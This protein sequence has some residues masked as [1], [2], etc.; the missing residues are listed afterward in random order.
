MTT[1]RLAICALLV[2]TCFS[3]NFVAAQE[4]T[5]F[6]SILRTDT[7]ATFKKVA[8]Y[9]TAHPDASDAGRAWKWLFITA[10]EERFEDEAV[11]YAESYLKGAKLDPLTRSLAQQTLAFGL[12]RSG[13]ADQVIDLF[14]GQLRFARLQNGGEF[15]DLGLR[16]ATALRMSRQFDASKKVLEETANKF[17]LDGEVRN[18]C[19]N[20]IA[21]LALIGQPAPTIAASDTKGEPL[22]LSALKGKVVLVDFWATNCGPCL[23]EFPNLKEIY[24]QHH[25]AGFEIIGVSLDG[26]AALVEAF[27]SRAQLPWRMIVAESEVDKLREKY[28]VR[29]I[30]SLYLVDQ[31][32]KVV[33][34]DV[35]GGD[36]RDSIEALLKK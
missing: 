3:S 13:Q 9:A 7:K 31:E 1:Q 33:Q 16:L 24:A 27:T 28:F 6:S 15:V 20:K 30:P 21:K 4:P 18:I 14:Q 8:E 17:F 12:A 36:L 34:F 11:P 19:E 2:A 23:E 26:D 22:E 5:S 32:G 25:A 29:K 35:K 10:L